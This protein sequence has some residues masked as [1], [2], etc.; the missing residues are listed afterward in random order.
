VNEVLLVN[1]E[2]QH[3]TV[4]RRSSEEIRKAALD[5]GMRTLRDDGLVKVG[6]GLT[7]IEEILRVVV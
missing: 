7:S 3:L 4:Q 2:I 1:E 6:L 5:E